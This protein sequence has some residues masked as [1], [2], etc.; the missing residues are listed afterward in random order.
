MPYIPTIWKRPR[1]I[2]EAT[3]DVSPGL[4][5]IEQSPGIDLLILSSTFFNDKQDSGATMENDQDQGS[6]IPGAPQGYN[7]IV[8]HQIKV[9]SIMRYTGNVHY[10]QYGD[11]SIVVYSSKLNPQG[12]GNVPIEPFIGMYDPVIFDHAIYGPGNV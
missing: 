7:P 8:N 2:D 10:E 12:L 11:G 3:V 1:F 5:V 6:H 4:T 9:P